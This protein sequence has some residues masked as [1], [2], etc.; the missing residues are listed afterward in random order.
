MYLPLL[1]VTFSG[2][3]FGAE[4]EK[5]EEKNITY[6]EKSNLFK[7][8]MKPHFTAPLT[9]HTEGEKLP[10]HENNLYFISNE[11][12]KVTITA[13][14]FSTQV[15]DLSLFKHEKITVPQVGI[16]KIF[17]S[18]HSDPH[19]PLEGLKRFNPPLT[20]SGSKACLINRYLKVAALFANGA[21]F[22]S[23]GIEIEV[24]GIADSLTLDASQSSSK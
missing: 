14:D 22:T 20:F 4:N 15:V 1:L 19:T 18:M 13:T 6:D 3:C 7:I 23:S 9:L 12:M 17:A 24:T 21:S 11:K 10:L 8:N 16:I 2:S 5:T